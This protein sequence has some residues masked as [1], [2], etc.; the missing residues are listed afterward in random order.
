MQTNKKNPFGTGFAS[1]PTRGEDFSA[2]GQ[3][4][5]QQQP[6]PMSMSAWQQ[7]R[8]FDNV[9]DAM[10]NQD[11]FA[12]QFLKNQAQY[13]Q[14]LRAGQQPQ[15]V[16]LDQTMVQANDNIAS[17]AYQ[18]N[19]FA[20]GNVD[21]IMGM[22]GQYGIQAPEGFRD[23]LI[24][25][26]GQQSTPPALAPQPPSVT[27]KFTNPA[28]G[29][30]YGQPAPQMGYGPGMGQQ[31]GAGGPPPP[32][33]FAPGYGEA[34][35][36]PPGTMFTTDFRDGDGDGIDDRW[37]PGP[38]I[39]P[40]QQ[41]G[42][43]QQPP[44][45]GSPVGP[46]SEYWPGLMPVRPPATGS[47]RPPV[48]QAPAQP[49]APW[50]PPPPPPWGYR[51]DAERKTAEHQS[52]LIWLFNQ[53]Q[54]PATLP[55]QARPPQPEPPSAPVTQ[56]PGKEPVMGLIVDDGPLA[57]WGF[58]ETQGPQQPP[59]SP[60]V[61]WR[62]P[63]GTP[64]YSPHPSQAESVR[65]SGART[66]EEY[67]RIMEGQRRA[68]DL[69]RRVEEQAKRREQERRLAE[70][71]ARYPTMDPVRS[72]QPETRG[73][74]VGWQPNQQRAADAARQREQ[75][76][77]S[78]GYIEGPRKSNGEKTWISPQ[79]QAQRSERVRPGQAQPAPERTQGTPYVPPSERPRTPPKTTAK[80]R[81][82]AQ[83]LLRSG[84]GMR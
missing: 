59:E 84:M 31:P 70:M 9:A 4:Q 73:Q 55:H 47:P 61:W 23:Q 3:K 56:R 51:D 65:A 62:S 49:P 34:I 71:Q 67:S 68:E 80:D 39:R 52:Y 48:P 8:Q 75:E 16:G 1:S 26:L 17:G 63:D 22:F 20:T 30:P 2:Y 78:Q 25:N 6:Q 66:P 13:N 54:N 45:T 7:P 64:Q 11:A 28:T 35:N 44:A 29:L 46:G 53:N 41:P 37:Q 77:L 57:N 14:G 76:L 42:M 72:S 74:V 33:A 15:R 21:A 79:Q 5:T 27:P 18:G 24:S 36:A 19:P 40:P 32:A 83:A 10:R 50:Q 38:G 58:P 43:G 12:Q 82:K 60:R 81:A 69:Y